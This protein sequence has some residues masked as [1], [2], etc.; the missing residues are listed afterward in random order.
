MS[1]EDGVIEFERAVGRETFATMNRLPVGARV[2]GTVGAE[3]TGGK[4]K[5]C[6][7]RDQKR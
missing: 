5:W 2:E 6:E 7:Q 3:E 4:G 1:V